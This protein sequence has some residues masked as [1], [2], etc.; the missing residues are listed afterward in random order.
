MYGLFLSDIYST[1]HRVCEVNDLDIG[2][3]L[4]TAVGKWL[5]SSDSTQDGDTVHTTLFLGEMISYILLSNIMLI[6]V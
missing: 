4:V 6:K 5:L 3:V 1:V 2:Q